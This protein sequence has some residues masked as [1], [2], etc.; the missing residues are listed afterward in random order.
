M[1]LPT[2]KYVS[3]CAVLVEFASEVSD[4]ANLQVIAFDKAAQAAAINGVVE[5]VPAM[6]NALIVFDPS[7]TTHKA[8]GEAAMAL[9]PL[10]DAATEPS[11]THEFSVYYGPDVAPDLTAVSK[12]TGL[13]TEAVINAHCAGRYRA[14][15]Y[16]FAP[17]Y[18]YLS[19]VPKV[20]QVPRKTAPVRDIA[21]GSVMIAAAQC[22]ITTLVMPT[23]WSIIGYTD[24]PV[25]R[26]D[27]KDPF[28][29][30][31]GDTITFRR[32]GTEILPAQ[33]ADVV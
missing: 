10:N 23:G 13:S 31:V 3:D 29:I 33:M 20:I 14:S 30:K 7:M 6:V 1:S 8:V 9:F 25:M 19:G 4:A 21:K 16:G 26:D 17:G 22:L 24:A 2:L 15:M 12:A 32:A 27:P 11:Q 28:L 5:I 18:A